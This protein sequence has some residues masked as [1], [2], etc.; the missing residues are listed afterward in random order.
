VRGQH[1]DD[2]ARVAALVERAQRGDD[3]AFESL[4]GTYRDRI[5]SYV[6]RMV[7]DPDEALDISQDT[8]L[9]AYQSLSRFRGSASFQTW[10]YRIATNLSIDAIRRSKRRQEATVSLDAPVDTGEG[11][12]M[13]ELADESRGPELAATGRAVQ[14]EVAAALEQMSPTLRPVLV[15]YDLQGMSYQEIA[16][17]LGCPLGT[18]KSRLFNARMQ[19]KEL[20]AER[21]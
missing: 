4:V 2:S 12:V 13:R 1:S 6:S 3:R 19:L 8:F 21:L 9:R 17:V 15:M 14:D 20:L 16:E 18:V 10:L 11:Q 5:H 7:R